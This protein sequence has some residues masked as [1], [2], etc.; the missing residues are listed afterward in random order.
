MF[1]MLFTI[2]NLFYTN[3]GKMSNDEQSQGA[4]AHRNI[5]W[6]HGHLLDIEKKRV[7]CKWCQKDMNGGI[8]YLKQHIIGMGGNAK[9]VI[10][11]R[12]S[13]KKK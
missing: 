7:R 3:A 11:S 12:L 5:G 10:R 2:F 4:A 8:Y 13:L 6:Q 1:F 9:N